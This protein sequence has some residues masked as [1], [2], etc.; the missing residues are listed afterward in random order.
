MTDKIVVMSTCGSPEEAQKLARALIE[1][2]L[3]AC[4]NI[5]ANTRSVYRWRGAVEEADEQL[6]IIKTRR[7]L[8]PAV[9]AEIERL[10]SYEV[11]E[12]LALSVVEGS[13]AYLEWLEQELPPLD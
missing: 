13:A 4:V 10:H 9:R 2:R 7:D 3:A 1:G 6:L 8:L 12:I 11:P 5:V